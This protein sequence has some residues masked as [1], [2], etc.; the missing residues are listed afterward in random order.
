MESRWICF[1][2][3]NFLMQNKQEIVGV[4]CHDAGGA[5]I[6]S[7]YILLN[8]IKAKYCL[9]GPAIRVFERKFG[10][11]KNNSLID[12][13]NESSWLLSGTSW[14]SNLEYNAIRE[15]IKQDKRIVVF[16]EHW[17][18]YPERFERN[19][20]TLL[21]DEIWVGD[22]YAKN[23]AEGC[24]E[25]TN[26]ELKDN[27]YL[28]IVRKSLSRFKP[29][30]EME[31]KYTALYV[32]ENIS[33]HM[34]LKYEDENYLGYTEHDS[35]KLFLDNIDKINK[36]IDTIILRPHPSDSN[37]Q[38]KYNWIERHPVYTL[39]DVQFSKEESLLQDIVDCDIVVGAESMAMVVGMTAEKRVVSSIPKE[40]RKCVLP[41]PEIEHILKIK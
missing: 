24:F 35:L 40:G 38:E 32:C 28:S 14:Q 18:N 37:P 25:N 13:V 23:I 26:I 5:E 9:K 31:G 11:I 2:S 4:I 22:V 15:S 8:N 3:V 41:F 6:V 19:G 12:L 1:I 27:P 21:P 10:T 20:I 16:L 30:K 17:I 33:R 39:Y 7:S 34:L 29:K 36:N